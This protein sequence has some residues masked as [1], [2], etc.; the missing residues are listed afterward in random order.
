M[1]GGRITDERDRKLITVYA[2]EIFEDALVAPEKWR[3][4]GTEEFNYVY[5]AD[6]ANTKH[7]NVAELFNPDY[8][9]GEIQ[10][11]FENRD[12]PS[13]FGQ[14]TNAE[15]SSQI[16]DTNELLASILSLQPQ[17]VSEGGKSP[18]AQTLEVIEPIQGS[19]PNSI[20][21]MALKVKMIKDDSPLTVVL[22]QE[23]QRYNVLLAIMRST[24]KELVRGIQGLVVISPELEKM[25][26]SLMQN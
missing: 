14:H 1:Y 16:G 15:I 23:I 5:P 7:P 6:E 26:T 19:I 20:D 24:L 9:M 12:Q 2:K 21:V 3:P 22:H 13:A 4:Y 25:M 10:K 8:F 17:V 11:H 18:E